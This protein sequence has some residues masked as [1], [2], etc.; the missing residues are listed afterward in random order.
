MNEMSPL[1]ESPRHRPAQAARSVRW[2][3]IALIPVLAG[4][5]FA[6]GDRPPARERSAPT[7][8]A[9]D[10]PDVLATIGNDPITW[11]DI[12]AVAGTDLDRMDLQYRHS[13]S[14][15]VQT[16]LERVLRDRMFEAEARRQQRTVAELVALEAGRPVEPTSGE[17]A[18]WYENNRDRVAGRSLDQIGPQIA[19]FLREQRMNAA[20]A[21]LAARL[22]KEHEVVVHYEPFR[23]QLDNDGA[24]YIGGRDAPVTLVEFS[25]FDCPFC[26]RFATTL[27]RLN[28]TF[29]DDLRIV[30]RQFPLASI[31]PNAFKAAEAS[32]CAHEQNRFWEMHDAMFLQQGRLG[33]SS[34]KE[35]ARQIGLDGTRFDRCL[36][37]GRFVEQ[38]QND[39]REAETMG[40]TGTPAVFVNGL[41]LQAGAQPYEVVAEAVQRELDRVRR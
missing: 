19:T 9:D 13:R 25:D 30:Y 29:G 1:P 22:E 39:M 15:L 26:A 18:E 33:V 14:T 38:V 16:T 23:F 5:S 7:G 31:H 41:P 11:A 6:C 40:V 20:A 4:L 34:L 35:I 37:T 27:K 36:D 8:D 32:L 10:I 17:V 21:S 3:A 2:L 12:H 28:A 24:P